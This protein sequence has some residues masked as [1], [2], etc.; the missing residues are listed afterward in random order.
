M[1]GPLQPDAP[2]TP[3]LYGK[4]RILSSSGRF[5]LM[6][7]IIHDPWGIWPTSPQDRVKDRLDRS[8]TRTGDPSLGRIHLNPPSGVRTEG[9]EAGLDARKACIEERSVV[10]NYVSTT[11]VRL[12]TQTGPDRRP[13]ATVGGGFRNQGVG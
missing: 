6:I 10:G 8:F 4:A 7:Q 9:A 11:E 13:N 1:D 12:T 3:P 5:L 2:V